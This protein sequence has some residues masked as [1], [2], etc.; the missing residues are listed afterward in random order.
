MKKM[1]GALINV[2]CSCKYFGHLIMNK[3]SVNED[4]K[5]QMR[6]FYGKANMLLCTAS[7]CSYHVELQLLSSYCGSLYTFVVQLH[8]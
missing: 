6:S 8:C 7:Q 3:L 4:I 5:G 2:E 1:N